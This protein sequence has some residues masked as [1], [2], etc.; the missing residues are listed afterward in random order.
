MVLGGMLHGLEHE[1]DP[2]PVLAG[3]AYRDTTP[4]IPLSWPEALAEFERSDFAGH[5]LGERFARLYAQTRRGEM[6]EFNSHVST[7]EYSWYLTTV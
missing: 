1:L 4:T 3:N 6:Q 2:G 7:L 5:C